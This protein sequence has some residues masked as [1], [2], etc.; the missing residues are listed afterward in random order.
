LTVDADGCIDSQWC[1]WYT[2]GWRSDEQFSMCL[3]GSRQNSRIMN[4]M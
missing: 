1:Q 2:N 3:A 4:Q